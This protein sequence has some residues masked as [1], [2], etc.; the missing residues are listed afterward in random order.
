MVSPSELI[1]RD[2]TPVNEE[3][4]VLPRWA[5]ERAREVSA[6]M[7][8]NITASGAHIIGNINALAP[9]EK[10]DAPEHLPEITSVPS[11]LPGWT[12]A[13]VIISS[14]ISRGDLPPT[15]TTSLPTAWLHRATGSQLLREVLRRIQIRVGQPLGRMAGH[16]E[17]KKDE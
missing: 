4:I 7:V 15:P 10:I 13:G 17:R 6:E 2:R 11:D 3:K 1:K 16:S 5:L 9:N 14:G 8:R 12:A